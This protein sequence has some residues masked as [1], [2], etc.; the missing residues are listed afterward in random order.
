MY[1]YMYHLS[2]NC[3][4]NYITLEMMNQY[5]VSG[6]FHIFFGFSENPFEVA[7]NKFSGMVVTY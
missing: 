3:R 2:H 4:L 5:S 7:Q 1:M 6:F